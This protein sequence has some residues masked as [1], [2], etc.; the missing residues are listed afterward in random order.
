M[1]SYQHGYHAGN[2][3]DVV[4]HIT[5]CRIL[6][7]LTQKDKALFYL[8]THAGSGFYDLQDNKTK[9]TGEVN[10]GIVPLWQVSNTLP[11]LFDPYIRVIESLNPDKQLRYYPGSPS[12]ALASLRNQ[13]R[14]TCLELHPQEFHQLKTIPHFNKRVFFS[15]TNGITA[16]EALLPPPER[17]GLI[18]IDPSYEIKTEYKELANAVNKALHRFATGVYCIWYPILS[19]GLHA[20]LIEKIQVNK[21]RT[22]LRIEFSLSLP[23]EAGM[24]GCGLLII[25]PPYN[26][27]QEMKIILEYLTKIFNPNKSFYLIE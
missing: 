25:N 1:L 20:Q 23:N 7:Y 24:T 9:K 8:E 18:F 15:N 12:L 16:L 5:L 21:P 19:R 4:K 10:T 26:L 11:P 3:A 17:R 14:A 27:A 2:F 22:K 13:D 6:N